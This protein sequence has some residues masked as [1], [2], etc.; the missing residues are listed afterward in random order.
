MFNVLTLCLFHHCE[1]LVVFNSSWK[2]TACDRCN[3]MH[4]QIHIT[5]TCYIFRVRLISITTFALSR[6][7]TY[8]YEHRQSSMD[9]PDNLHSTIRIHKMEKRKIDYSPIHNR[10]VLWNCYFTVGSIR[11]Y[12]QSASDR[13][14]S[15][16]ALSLCHVDV[17]CSYEYC[18]L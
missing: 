2:M 16:R 4:L 14:D 8:A 11:I 17:A 9:S 12:C 18:R 7:T 15:Y 3:N 1:K 10:N 6:M 5:H 13:K